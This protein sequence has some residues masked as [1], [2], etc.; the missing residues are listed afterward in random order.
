MSRNERERFLAAARVGVLSVSD[1]RDGVRA[2]L[3]LPVWYGYEPGGEIVVETGRASIKAQLLRA[4][5]RFSLC[6][7]DER[8]P[9]R[10]VSVEG[11]VIAVEDPIDPAVRTALAERYLP[12]EEARAYLAAT[13][14]QLEHDVA[15]RMR[16]H[17][18]RTADFAEFAAELTDVGA[19]VGSDRHTA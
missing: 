15:F 2:P 5:G 4:A 14:D 1:T 17:R 13:I 12:T 16:P 19:D 3:A 10:Y 8:Q 6:V 18:W 7:Q 11:P 9:Y